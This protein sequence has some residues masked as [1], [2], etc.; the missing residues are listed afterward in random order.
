MGSGKNKRVVRRK[1]KRK[2]NKKKLLFLVIV[3]V[4]F[5]FG[6]FKLTQGAILAIQY[7][8]PKK[9]N[10]TTVVSPQ[11][12]YETLPTEVDKNIKMKYTI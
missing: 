2:I 3:V 12:E 4:L 1:S 10:I 5:V 8:I 9:E 6:I 7:I 11:I